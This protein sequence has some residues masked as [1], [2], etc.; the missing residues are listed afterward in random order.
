M[1]MSANKRHK[2]TKIEIKES[3]NINIFLCDLPVGANFHEEEDF[4]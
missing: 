2:N 3:F 4:K 1:S